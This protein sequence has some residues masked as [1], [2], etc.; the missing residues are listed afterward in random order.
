MDT[1]YLRN[2]RKRDS[3]NSVF[4]RLVEQNLPFSFGF[5]FNVDASF[6]SLYNVSADGN[7]ADLFGCRR[8]AGN[9]G[10]MVFDEKTE[11]RIFKSGLPF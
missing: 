1:V 2:T 6:K 7:G 4:V 11:V 3:Y 5:G 10:F 9:D 8:F